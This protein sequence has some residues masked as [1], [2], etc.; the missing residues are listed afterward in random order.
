[1]LPL[2]TPTR[3]AGQ[4]YGSLPLARAAPGRPRRLPGL[5]LQTRALRQPPGPLQTHAEVEGAEPEGG[6]PAAQ[7]RGRDLGQAR[8][9]GQAVYCSPHRLWLMWHR[10]RRPKRPRGLGA[11]KESLVSPPG[12][13]RTALILH[14]V[15]GRT[16]E[17]HSRAGGQAAADARCAPPGGAFWGCGR[18]ESLGFLPSSPASRASCAASQLAKVWPQPPSRRSSPGPP[19]PAPPGGWPASPEA[20]RAVPAA[21]ELGVPTSAAASVHPQAFPTQLERGPALRHAPS[22]REVPQSDQGTENP[23]PLPSGFPRD[24]WPAPPPPAPSEKLRE[25]PQTTAPSPAL[26]EPLATP[27]WAAAA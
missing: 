20:Q 27:C 12:R 23:L 7:Q 19:S 17:L 6:S 15:G 8:R 2:S 13:P 21:A 24:S 10:K 9:G 3:G 25:M 4:A 22:P 11:A 16:P 5:L 14:W 1:M 18:A 26:L